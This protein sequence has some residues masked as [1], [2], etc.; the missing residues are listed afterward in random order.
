MDIDAFVAEHE[1]QWDR[2]RS[3]CA[4]SRHL[5][6]TEVDEVV[7]LYQRT[8]THLATVRGSAY[9]PELEARLSAL[10]ANARSVITAA[11]PATLRSIAG[12]FSSS[13]PAALYRLRYWA[14]SV[15]FL[16]LLLALTVA[17]YVMN[18]PSVV[19]GYLSKAEIDYLVN[20][21]FA[22]YYTANPASSWSV[23]L[24]LHN[25]LAALTSLLLGVLVLPGLLSLY[26]NAV[27]TGLM[28]GL[29]IGHGRGDVFWGLI[30]PHGMLELTAV[31]FSIAAGLRLAWAWIAPGEEPRSRSLARHGR[32]LVIVGIGSGLW[33]A[34]SA[35]IEAFVTPSGWP[36][37]VRLGIGLVAVTAFWLYVLILGRR[38]HTAGVTGD[39]DAALVNATQPIE[40]AR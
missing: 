15:W 9:D 24:W 31:F 29:V 28:A 3:L 5:R 1:P 25:S 35:V 33:L 34:V 10:L 8:A 38:A 36:A 16:F 17:L 11:P 39:T 21:E 40:A 6:G 12:F 32:Q 19:E 23:S 22:G 27:N 2:L 18:T 14:L 26:A 30:L 37:T 13:L 7:D 4:R 20:Y